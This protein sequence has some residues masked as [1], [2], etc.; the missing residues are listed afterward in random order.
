L[1]IRTIKP[2]FFTDATIIGLPFEARLAFIGLWCHAD[3]D[4]RLVCRARDLKLSL[5]P[6]QPIDF[7]KMLSLMSDAKLIQLYTIDGEAYIQ[8]VNFNKHQI[9]HVKEKAS[10]LPAPGEH[11]ASTVRAPVEPLWSGK[12]K[13]R[14]GNGVTTLA[15]SPSAKVINGAL[16]Y[17]ILGPRKTWPLEQEQIDE[18]AK[19]YSGVDV[20]AECKKA[21]AWVSASNLKKTERGMNR[22][23]VNWLN[24]ATDRGGGTGTTPRQRYETLGEGN[25]RRLGITED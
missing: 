7:S 10:T 15:S 11:S 13:G 9:P 1:R 19:L 3:R 17:P 24:R 4:G 14:E 2:S 8:I 25:R 21:L 23:L 6:D 20:M 16:W 22:F 18:W 12:G 5:F